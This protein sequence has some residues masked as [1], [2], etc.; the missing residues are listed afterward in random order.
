M[1]QKKSK[2]K[3][4]ALDIK[5]YP[6]QLMLLQSKGRQILYGGAA[7]GG[8]SYAARCLAVV[9][10]AAIP[11]L[12]SWFLRRYSDD[13]TLNHIEGPTGF[14]AMLAPWIAQKWCEIV[15]G[16]IRFKW[17]SR[18]FLRSCQYERDLPR[19]LGP[20]IHCL[21]IEE[22]GQFS[23]SMIRFIRARLRIPDALKI[24][25]EYKDMF[26]RAIYTSN[27]GGVG[28]NFLKRM[29]VQGKEPFKIYEVSDDEGGMPSQYIPAKLDD[30]PSIN[31]EE[32]ARSLQGLG[33]KALVDS[34]LD[35]NWDSIV[36]AF[37]PELE[38]SVHIIPPFA[39]PN[40]W[41][42][43]M[44]MD[45]GACGEGDPFSVMWYAVS[46]GSIYDIPRG[47]LVFYRSYYGRGLP[48]V[49]VNSVANEIRIREAGEQ[50][51]DR[52]AG[53]DIMEK[54]GTGPSIFEIFTS[55][56]I[57]FRRADMRRVSG[58]QQM[59]ER[60]VGKDG[61]PMIYFFTTMT[62]EVETIQSIQHDKNDRNDAMAGDDHVADA[63]RY[64]CMA[65]P[66]VRDQPAAQKPI[67]QIFTPPTMDEM[68]SMRD[69]MMSPRR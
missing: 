6:K 7:G 39:I 57:H 49:T 35:G 33:S 19:L 68:W 53:G 14:R 63:V 46:D 61:K 34:L 8:K 48:K 50:I 10:S 37:F 64:C 17:G 40:Y 47:A 32:Y 13:L 21:F 41:V 29:F 18:I 31:R 12:N 3:P 66:W 69:S 26:P 56:G 58:W 44:G 5:L 38:K 67:D 22:A 2:Q 15:D 65:R 43:S 54:R 52:V 51:I 24:P 59:R 36:G 55:Y 62:L 4:I 23:E 27:P 28:H 30:N 9:Y 16:E 45:W 11:G 60:L 42:R 20:E 25:D 1:T